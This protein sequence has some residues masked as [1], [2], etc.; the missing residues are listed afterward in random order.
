MALA[1]YT[2]SSLR[3]SLDWQR[4]TYYHKKEESLWLCV[5]LH[6]CV[7]LGLCVFLNSCRVHGEASPVVECAVG[8]LIKG[9]DSGTAGCN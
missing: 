6:L 3:E 5:H 9:C 2:H 1:A 4:Q 7:Y 8:S